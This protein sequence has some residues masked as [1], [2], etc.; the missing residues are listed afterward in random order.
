M[1]ARKIAQTLKDNDG[2]RARTAAA[3]QISYKLL[4]EKLKDYGLAADAD[5]TGDAVV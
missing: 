3:L 2:D 4:V 1:E 5:S